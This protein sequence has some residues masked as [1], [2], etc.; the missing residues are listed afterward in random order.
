MPATITVFLDEKLP[1]TVKKTLRAH[2]F[3]CSFVLMYD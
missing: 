2:V 3:T 1:G